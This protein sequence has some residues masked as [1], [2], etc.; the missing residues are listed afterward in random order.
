MRAQRE[1]EELL[2]TRTAS[3]RTPTVQ[4]EQ[5]TSCVRFVP[6]HVCMPAGFLC[7]VPPERRKRVPLR[8]VPSHLLSP[9]SDA[10]LRAVRALNRGPK[11][12]RMRLEQAKVEQHLGLAVVT[13]KGVWAQL[14]ARRG[15]AVVAREAKPRRVGWQR[16]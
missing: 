13:R 16:E 5:G 12:P 10:P 3:R 7:D 4:Y 15:L 9:A 8:R 2:V 6:R 14:A 11:Y 1:E